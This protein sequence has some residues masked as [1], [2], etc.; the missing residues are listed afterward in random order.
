MRDEAER[1]QH[2]EREDQ[3]AAQIGD[4]EGIYCRVQEGGVQHEC[5]NL[6]FDCFDGTAR[7]LDLL[8]GAGTELVSTHRQFYR[9]V[10]LTK[11]F[12]GAAPAAQDARDVKFLG[13]DDTPDGKIVQV[14]DIDLAK[15]DAERVAE[16]ASIRQLADQRQLATLEVRRYSAARSSVL[17]LGAL[18]TSLDF[19]AAM[20][21]ADSNALAGGAVGRLKVVRTHA[22]SLPPRFAPDARL[23]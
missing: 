15:L 10:T 22:A 16:A 8:A 20:A 7:G 3:L 4:L 6:T 23:S 9:Q 17:A 13:P 19:A 12:Y 11:N 1:H 18:A 2:A 14:A 5:G 21:A